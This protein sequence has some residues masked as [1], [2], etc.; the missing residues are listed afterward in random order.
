VVEL[1]HRF[2]R[3]LR[4]GATAEYQAQGAG[5]WEPLPIEQGHLDSL[6]GICS[7]AMA[8]MLLLQVPRS[9]VLRLTEARRG[10]FAALWELASEHAFTGTA[11]A[12][13]VR[14][15]GAVDPSLRC[16]VFRYTK[17]DRIASEVTRAIDS[18]AVPLLE[19]ESRTWAHWTLLAGYERAGGDP[20]S[21]L[22][23]LDPDHRAPGLAC[24]NA[25]I[26]LDAKAR[27]ARYPLAYRAIGRPAVWVRPRSLLV[28]ARAPPR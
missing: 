8:A 4:C 26:E 20:P 10:P 6:C 3:G 5:K 22:L 9:Q 19:F 7:L 17:P 16:R 18:G 14:M 27:G 23:A 24:F 15:A 28:I 11:P 2:V 13:L 1:H 25:R 21:A 12:D